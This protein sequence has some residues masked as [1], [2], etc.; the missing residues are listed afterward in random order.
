MLQTLPRFVLPLCLAIVSLVRPVS[1]ADPAPGDTHHFKVTL[2]SKLDMTVQGQK[3]QLVAA[4]SLRYNWTRN[5]A[6][7][8]LVFESIEV[9]T[10]INGKPLM[11][12]HSA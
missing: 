11:L 9:K 8:V 5:T 10:D 4:S 2:D 1:A 6:E 3:Q 7:R 12:R